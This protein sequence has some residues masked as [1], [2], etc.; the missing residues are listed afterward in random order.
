V[1]AF[2]RQEDKNPRHRNRP[3]ESSMK[4]II[5]RTDDIAQEHI[6][7]NKALVD[8]QTR[9]AL[10][11][12]AGDSIEIE[13]SK[14]TSATVEDAHADEEGRQIISI[15]WVTAQNAGVGFGKQVKVRRAE[16]QPA[17]EISVAVPADE[18]RRYRF[19]DHAK[20]QIQ[21][22]LLH[23]CVMKGDLVLLHGVSSTNFFRLYR[24]EPLLK[25]IDTNPSGVVRIDGSTS[26]RFTEEAIV[27][28][29]IWIGDERGL[30]DA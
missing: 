7:K 1:L 10:D 11:V 14:K 29:E 6:G 12:R 9:D 4:E 18:T 13:N 15:D 22:D 16:V 26:V 2:K 17:K 23:K 21:K 28:E 5:L 8:G 19:R 3:R 20:K 24:T 30:S 25:I 27:K